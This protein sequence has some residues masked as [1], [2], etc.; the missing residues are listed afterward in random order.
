MRV[1]RGIDNLP[2]FNN[3]VAT[4]GSFDGVHCGHRELLQRV[5]RIAAELRGES[6]VLTF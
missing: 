4:M 3:A 5:K 1:F 2:Q 6:I